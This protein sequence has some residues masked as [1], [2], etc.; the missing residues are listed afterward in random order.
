MGFDGNELQLLGFS[1]V[2]TEFRD[3]AH[4]PAELGVFPTPA[5]GRLSFWTSAKGL[6]GSLIPHA[7]VLDA[8]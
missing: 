1:V 8:G 5:G 2:G 3:M 4:E 7:W 6:S